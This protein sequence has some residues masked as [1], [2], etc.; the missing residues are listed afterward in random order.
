MFAFVHSIVII[1]TSSNIP[2]DRPSTT[3][4]CPEMP[5]CNSSRARERENEKERKKERLKV[6]E[7]REVLVNAAC[8]IEGDV[9]LSY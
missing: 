3:D 4:E 7:R 1:V 9:T 6:V 5:K 8:N 2:G